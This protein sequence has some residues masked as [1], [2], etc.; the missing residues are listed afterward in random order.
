MLPRLYRRTARRD[1]VRQAAHR[2]GAQVTPMADALALVAA[3]LAASTAVHMLVLPLLPPRVRG[4]A[5]RWKMRLRLRLWPARVGVEMV[6]RAV[7][8]EGGPAEPTGDVRER[9]AASMREA[10][11]GVTSGGPPLNARSGGKTGAEPV[12]EG[13]VRRQRGL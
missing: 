3:G 5:S 12:G 1:A 4:G 2:A 10:G 13:R 8:A 7:A 6:S 11:F 9:V